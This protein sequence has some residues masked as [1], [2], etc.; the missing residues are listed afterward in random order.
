MVVVD[1]R[2]AQRQHALRGA[3]VGVGEQRVVADAHGERTLGETAHEHAVEV[4]PE[5]ER[6]VAH[7]D[8]LA[9]ATDPPEVGVEL[10]LERAAEHVE[11]GGG[12]DRIE[13]GEAIERRF[14]LVGGLLLRLRPCATAGIVG[15]ELAQ[16]PP[17]PE[18][19]IAPA[20]AGLGTGCER[21]AE[22]GDERVERA[23]RVELVDVP[24]GT[25][26][27]VGHRELLGQLRLQRVGMTLESLVPLRC[28]AH[29]ARAPAD[30]LPARRWHRPPAKP[31]RCARQERHHV[32]SMEVAIGE[33]EEAEQR[34]PEHAL[35]ER[36][37]RGAV[38]RDPGR[39]ELFVHEPCVRLRGAVEDRH[40]LERHAVDERRHHE[41]D[42][43]AHFVVGVG[44]RDHLGAV[45]WHHRTRF[46]VVELEAEPRDR[47]SDPGIGARHAGDTG[48]DRERRVVGDR[49]QQPGARQ[50]QVLRQ[51]QHDRAQ[52]G[53]DRTLP[54]CT[55]ATAVSIRSRSS[56]HSSESVARAAR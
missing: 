7:E 43:G 47:G 56:Y 15:E 30:A 55:A 2:R 35:G 28:S 40:P 13:P 24:V 19:Q 3:P 31:D 38:V 42:R 48:D 36:A 27:A 53:E 4:E 49:A 17:R 44:R 10:E 18:R 9:E 41:P 39:L 46:H 34:T 8:A 25:R 37:D 45:R 54:S 51:V 14:D 32:V 29:D 11:A 26:F 22:L 12:L 5:A 50:R 6:D 20:D 16:Q 1:A 21:V 23:C 52:V 33:R